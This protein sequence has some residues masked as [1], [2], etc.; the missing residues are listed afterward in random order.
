MDADPLAV[1]LAV[2]SVVA[3]IVP[4][5]MEAAGPAASDAFVETVESVMAAE[6]ATETLPPVAPAVAV[7]VAVLVEFARSV[8]APPLSGA[9]FATEAFVVMVT[10]SRAT[11]AP[12]PA[13]DEPLV[14]AVALAADVLVESAVK[15]TAPPAAFS[16]PPPP[17]VAPVVTFP[18][19]SAKEPATP[20]LPPLAPL[21]AVAVRSLL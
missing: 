9:P 3:R 11:D 18:M 14:R 20:T 4:A 17:S 10:R 21:V 5:P 16:E 19:T 12:M 1:E 13:V 8:R 6:G 7:L 2:A 15:L